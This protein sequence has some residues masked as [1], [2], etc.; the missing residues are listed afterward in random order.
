MS[1]P[2]DGVD[3]ASETWCIK[4][5]GRK[6]GTPGSEVAAVTIDEVGEIQVSLC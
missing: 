6:E 5:T 1:S 4:D 2:N 3:V